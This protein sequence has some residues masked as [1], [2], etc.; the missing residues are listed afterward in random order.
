MLNSRPKR[1]GK[2]CRVGAGDV[3]GK[4][5]ENPP[6][7]SLSGGFL[8][9][10]DHCLFWTQPLVR[11]RR[12]PPRGPSFTAVLKRK[13][14]F[15]FLQLHSGLNSVDSLECGLPGSSV[16]RNPPANGGDTG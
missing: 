9:S 2:K 16:I 15:F 13:P 10:S 12:A 11:G 4:V 6:L 8:A 5:W 14:W 3:P 1:P 7:G